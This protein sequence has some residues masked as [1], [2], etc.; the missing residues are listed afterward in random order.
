MS[1]AGES[2]AVALPES[3]QQEQKN[4]QEE[5]QSNGQEKKS[6]EEQSS[7]KQA[8]TDIGPLEDKILRQIEVCR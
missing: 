6:T 4:T 2:E 5:Q 8:G 7:E 1:G 3:A